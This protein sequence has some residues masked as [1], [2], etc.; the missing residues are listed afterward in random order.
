MKKTT[1][2]NVASKIIDFV[3][4]N[5]MQADNSDYPSGLHSNGCTFDDRI[6]F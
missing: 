5:A 2:I 4:K 3:A 1:G 6:K